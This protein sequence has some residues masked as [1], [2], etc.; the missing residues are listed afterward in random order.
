MNQRPAFT[1]N[2]WLKSNSHTHTGH[3]D[4]WV[5]LLK[6]YSSG[7]KEYYLAK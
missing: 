6:F 5:S 3:K 4:A 1:E 2:L 7:N